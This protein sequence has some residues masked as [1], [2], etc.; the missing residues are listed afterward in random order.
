MDNSIVVSKYID[1][2]LSKKTKAVSINELKKHLTNY[3]EFLLSMKDKNNIYMEES[4]NS[5]I[6]LLVILEDERN[7][8]YNEKNKAE[9]SF[10]AVVLNT[11][12]RI[13]DVDIEKIKSKT[14]KREVVQARDIYNSIVFSYTNI[15]L[16]TI[17]SFVNRKHC[18]IYN[19]IKNCN[20]ERI[21]TKHKY[22][23]IVQKLGLTFKYR[24]KII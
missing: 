23:E 3:G 15:D 9:Q 22:D 17:T 7:Y 16:E 8:S 24:S 20:N 19:S 21:S 12:S 4:K 5:I 6:S 1:V 18:S 13:L 14:R 10:M 2:F 11:V